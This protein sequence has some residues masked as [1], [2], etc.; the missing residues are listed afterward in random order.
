MSQH[1]GQSAEFYNALRQ[2]EWK[3]ID[4]FGPSIRSRYRVTLQL[5]RKYIP[6]Q[7]SLLDC[8]CGIGALLK[9]FIRAGYQT[10]A[11]SDLSSEAIAIARHDLDCPLAVVDITRTD[12]IHGRQYDAIVCC[13]VL[14]HIGDDEQAL[15]VLRGALHPQGILII[16]VPFGQ[17]WWSA[18][19]EF[20][21]H[22]RRYELGEMERKLTAAGFHIVESFGWG[23][24]MYHW[25]H[26]FLVRQ[27]PRTVMGGA[28]RFFKRFIA[29]CL[30]VCFIPDDWHRSFHRA[31]RL[32]V[33]ARAR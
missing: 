2:K 21:G 16:S 25:Y 11:G 7:A 23:G 18:H 31:R 33:V 15:R 20:S 24:L 3:E 5:V 26:R 8:G 29:F 12:G 10:V 19:D 13:E 9:L 17:R 6:L 22:V 4:T 27:Q 30:Y 1:A 14:E 32:F 28:H